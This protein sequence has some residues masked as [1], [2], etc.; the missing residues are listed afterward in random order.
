MAV[1]GL[2]LAREAVA[3]D[4]MEGD[5]RQLLALALQ[6]VGM[7]EEAAEQFEKAVELQPSNPTVYVL[8]SVVLNGQQRWEAAAAAVTRGQAMLA[9]SSPHSPPR[10]PMADALAMQQDIA[11]R[12]LRGEP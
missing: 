6:T 1:D 11:E 8:E 4:P 3:I 9:Q 2:E 12:G 10:G 5:H 7:V